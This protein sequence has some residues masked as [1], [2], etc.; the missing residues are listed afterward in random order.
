MLYHNRPT[1]WITEMLRA[2]VFT[3]VL[4]PAVLADEVTLVSDRDNTLYEDPNG[5]VSAGI[6]QN[7]FCG[8]TAQLEKFLRRGLIRFDVAGNVPAGATMDAVELTLHVSASVSGPLPCG[9]HRVMAD[10]GEGTSSPMGAGGQGAPATPNDATWIHTFYDTQFWASEGGDFVATP[11]A[12]V[13]VGGIESYTWTSTPALLADVQGWLDS[14]ATNF[15]WLVHGEES[16]ASSAK[17]FDTR[18]NPVVAFRPALKIT[19]TAAC[20]ADI[21]GDGKVCQDDLGVLLAAF[22]SCLGQTNY[23][24]KANLATGGSSATCIDQS[25]LGVLLSEYGC[26]GCP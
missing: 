6:G 13:M 19:F 8:R 23:N 14:P 16:L 20:E 9:L 21:T 5:L 22:G 11:S 17:R 1:S 10:W 12:T 7:F 4:A 18:E 24:P 15:G 3:V 26:G 25:D 2:A